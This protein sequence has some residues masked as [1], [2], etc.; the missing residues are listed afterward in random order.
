MSSDPTGPRRPPPTIE[1]S[2]R[3][4]AR[5]PEAPSVAEIPQPEPQQPA[6][7]PEAAQSADASIR[8][9]QRALPWS[10]LGAGLAGGALVLAVAAVWTWMQPTPAPNPAPAPADTARLD[11]LTTRFAALE[12]AARR[13]PPAP[14]ADPA[15]AN[16][17]SA[18]EEAAKGAG[19]GVADL[20]Q[21]ADTLNTAVQ[22]ARARAATNA[23]AI[24]ELARKEALPPPPTPDP[25]ARLAVAAGNLRAALERG[26]PYMADLAAARAYGADARLIAALEP[27][28]ASGIP[29]DATLAAEF[30]A[31]VPALAR[32]AGASTSGQG[33][34]LDRLQANAEKLVRVRPADEPLGDDP[35]QVVTRAEIKVQSDP[36]AA[37]AEL[38]KL[39]PTQR[40]PADAW[41]RR[42]EAR[43]VAIEA[44]RKLAADAVAAL[45]N[46]PAA[47][48]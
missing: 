9:P 20:R 24:A 3:E 5:E 48:R 15:L 27:F 40:A 38:D 22:D 31:L 13:P 47:P 16:R 14:V 21:R 7:A 6:A 42:V 8:P 30:T 43:Q 46:T 28:A 23:S 10:H 19:Q 1:L 18:L 37:L 32:L 11:E 29:R 33:G 39:Q 17:V 36:R 45:A 44:S 25:Q 2:K 35:R 12:A 41:I 4:F 34:F 26:D